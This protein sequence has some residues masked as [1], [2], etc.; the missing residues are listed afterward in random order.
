MLRRTKSKLIECGNLVLPA[1]TE[2]TMYAFCPVLPNQQLQPRFV[3]LFTSYDAKMPYLG[4]MAPLL[5]LQKKVYMSILRKELPKLLALS[6]G[7]HQSLQNIVRQ[8]MNF[9][10]LS[11]FFIFIPF[12]CCS[13]VN[14]LVPEIH[15][16]K[17]ILFHIASRLS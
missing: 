9:S 6:S 13:T 2:I 14:S 17:I 3:C 16:G 1:L 7:N 10:P 11:S 12:I 5:S 8:F 4:R 15:I